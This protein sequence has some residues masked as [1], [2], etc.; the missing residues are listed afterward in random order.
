[1]E[2]TEEREGRMEKKGS[3]M[4]RIWKERGKGKEER[5]ELVQ[6]LKRGKDADKRKE[7]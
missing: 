5:R 4:K 2:R 1:M 3:G 6:K 7:D